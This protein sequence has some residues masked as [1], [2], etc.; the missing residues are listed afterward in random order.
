MICLDLHDQMYWFWDSSYIG[1]AYITFSP[2]LK[3]PHEWF[4]KQNC[5]KCSNVKLNTL[6]KTFLP[7]KYQEKERFLQNQGTFYD[8]QDT[9]FC[10]SL[11]KTF[12]WG[13]ISE[14]CAMPFHCKEHNTGTCTNLQSDLDA[15]A[16][17]MLDWLYHNRT[18][19][20]LFLIALRSVNDSAGKSSEIALQ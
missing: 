6:K 15:V 16:E 8:L 1:I 4:T 19:S 10:E 12:I 9:N 11:M 14:D 20:Q 13:F 18:L 5:R 2:H 17:M 7:S 3:G